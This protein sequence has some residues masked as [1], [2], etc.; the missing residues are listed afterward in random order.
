[1]NPEKNEQLVNSINAA[2][3]KINTP[4][5]IEHYAQQRLTP[6]Y[7]GLQKLGTFG[8]KYYRDG[9]EIRKNFK[10]TDSRV[11][12]YTYKIQWRFWNPLTIISIALI[13]ATVITAAQL[14]IGFRGVMEVAREMW[15]AFVINSKRSL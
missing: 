5:S 2:V 6:M 12:A 7:I 4:K 3:K 13:V 11:H 1:M 15:D 14:W 10:V 8:I 9:I